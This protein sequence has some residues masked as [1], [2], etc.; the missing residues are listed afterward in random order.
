MATDILLNE[1]GD[2]DFTEGRLTIV[3]EADQVRQ[4]WLIYI[5]TLLGEWFLNTAIGVPYIQKA[6]KKRL[7]RRELKQI[8]T[9]ATLEVPGVL[10]VNSVIINDL[11][12][13]TRFAEITV[14]A[15][16]TGEETA[17]FKYSG[18]IPPEGCGVQASSDFPLTLPCPWFWFDCQDPKNYSYN[19]VGSPRMTMQ[20]K[21]GEG[22]LIGQGDELLVPVTI[23]QFQSLFVDGGEAA[24]WLNIDGIPA[25]RKSTSIPQPSEFILNCTIF[26]VWRKV[27]RMG[28]SSPLGIMSFTGVDG[29][30]VT[31]EGFGLD[32][33]LP[34]DGGVNGSVDTIGYTE[35][36]G[37][38]SWEAESMVGSLEKRFTAVRF[39][40]APNIENN[41]EL[42]VWDN[43]L[44]VLVEEISQEDFDPRIELDGNGVIGARIDPADGTTVQ[45]PGHLYIGEVIGYSCALTDEE[46]NAMNSF[47]RE[48]WG[49]QFTIPEPS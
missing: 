9:T 17:T 29:D 30:G 21:M 33:L 7:G 16:I 8:F 3:R 41:G 42:K 27:N 1:C 38:S 14:E 22:Q 20:N 46:V 6:Y 43:S 45:K 23:N 13:A 26:I 34:G 25:L 36:T 31:K 48:K 35:E 19:P 18:S 49:T 24:A 15:V 37:L 2:I 39:T 10:A 5:R 40:G 44:P 12:V 4:A 11:N 47:L 32:W 28:E